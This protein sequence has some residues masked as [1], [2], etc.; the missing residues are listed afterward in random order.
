M[1]RSFSAAAVAALYAS[2][3][4]SFFPTLCKIDHASFS[5]P[6][7]IVNNPEPITYGGYEY[8]PFPFRFDPPAQN[9]SNAGNATITI[10]AI[11]D[12]ISSTI[13]ALTSAPTVTLVAAFVEGSAAP[14]ALIP[15]TFTVKN[16]TC[17]GTVLT[18]NLILDENLDNQMGPILFTPNLFPGVF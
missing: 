6:W 4:A 9:D 2:E 10:D 14:E 13:M 5:S 3:T 11:D 1:S 7:Y 12:S 16:I 15:W 8:Q 18:G 17:D